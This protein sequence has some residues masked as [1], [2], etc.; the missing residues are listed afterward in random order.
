MMVFL[1]VETEENNDCNMMFM[2]TLKEIRMS[3]IFTCEA[4][5]SMHSVR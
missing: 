1:M 4:D 3:A 5:A 2:T